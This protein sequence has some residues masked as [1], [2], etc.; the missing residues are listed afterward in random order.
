MK[1]N[2]SFRLFFPLV[3]LAGLPA[4]ASGQVVIN[5]YSCA[6]I[7]GPTDNFGSNEDWAELY[8]TTGSA[9]SL[10]GWYISNKA[11]NIIKWQISSASIP[12]NGRLIIWFSGRNINSGANLHTNFKL[13]QTKPDVLILANASATVVDSFTLKTHQ[14][15]HSRGRT[16]DGANT[17]AVFPTPT[18]NAANSGAWANYVTTPTLSV[19]PGFYGGTQ[20]VTITCPDPNTTIHYTTN[21][22][23]PTTTDPTYSGPVAVSTTTVLR[24]KAFSSTS[25]VPASFVASAT[26]FIGVTHTIAVVS[27]FGD[28][29][30]TLLGGNS[31]V[32]PETGLQYFN[33]SGQYK[34]FS[35]GLTNKHGN[36]SWS[37]PQRGIDF[38]SMDQY[39]YNYTIKEKLFDTK[40]RKSFQRVI[41]KAAANDNYPFEVPGSGYNWGPSSEL[42]GAHIRDAFVNHVCQTRG[43]YL[44]ERSYEPI[45]MY[46]NGQYW[47]VYELREKVDD[48]DF[49]NYYYN[50]PSYFKNTA[51]E[52]SLQ[53]LKTWGGTWSAYGGNTAQSDWMM[54][55]NYITGNSM[56]VQ[57]NYNTAAAQLN[58]K[59]FSDYIIQGSYCV[60]SDWLNWNT[61]WWHAKYVNATHKKWRWNLWDED[62]TFGQYINYTGIPNQSLTASPCDLTGLPDPGGQG[63]IPIFNALMQ[64]PGYKTYFINRYTDLLNTAFSCQ[65]LT[66]VLDSLKVILTPEMAAHCTKWGGSVAQWSSNWAAL[67]NYITQRCTTAF[68]ALGPPCFQLTGPHVITVDVSPA[69][70]GTVFLNSLHLQTF[71]WSG[72]YFGGNPIDMIA[73]ANTGYTFDHWEMQNHTPIAPTTTTTDSIGI[74]LATQ[75]DNFVAV[76]RQDAGPSGGTVMAVPTGFSPNGDGINDMLFVLGSF[77]KDL[78]FTV[79]D[80]WGQVI[81][82][83]SDR[84]TGWDGKFKGK[85]VG[86]GVYAYKLTYTKPDTGEFIQQSGNITLLR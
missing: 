36:D 3:I 14:K 73:K 30:A 9:V 19:A 18:F 44:D 55:K 48:A 41:L 27:V 10:N 63:M 65:T 39:G 26:Y 20:N 81:F 64:N 23:A 59:S 37:Y 25:N 1:F 75:G 86:S 79:Y 16:T 8:N 13:K 21:G 22:F 69:G 6:N 52:D 61:E 67:R 7:T 32:N 60:L 17:W 45:A 28:Q 58:V 49:T 12:A 70:A 74:D 57:A 29:L 82:E 71:Q 24:A 62:A 42:G 4:L 46:M 54:L 80:R 11:S 2:F 33:K 78:H 43:L 83:T 47:G 53:M 15:D 68:T 5:E 40:Q 77:Y 66:K 84:N 76:F 50:S 56:A 38:V 85:D 35:H 51:D 34:A 31:G 72:S